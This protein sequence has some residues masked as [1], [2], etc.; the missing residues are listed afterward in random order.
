MSTDVK[1]YSSFEKLKNIHGNLEGHIYTQ[2]CVDAQK[3]PSEALNSHLP[4]TLSQK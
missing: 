4:Q 2:D 1:M 3:R